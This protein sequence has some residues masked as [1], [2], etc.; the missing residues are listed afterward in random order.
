MKIVFRL[1]LWGSGTQYSMLFF[2][3]LVSLNMHTIVLNALSNQ[4]HTHIQVEF[5]VGQFCNS[6]EPS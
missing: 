5:N 2:N 6:Q 3:S 1:I 4:M